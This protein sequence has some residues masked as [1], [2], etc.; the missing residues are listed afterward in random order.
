M[1]PEWVIRGRHVVAQTEAPVRTVLTD[2]GRDV[3]ALSTS[4]LLARYFAAVELG[5]TAGL[6]RLAT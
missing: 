2:V 5:M 3:D 1:A 4:P 6:S